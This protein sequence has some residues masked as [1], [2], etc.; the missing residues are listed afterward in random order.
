M[1]Q[2]YQCVNCG[3]PVAFGAKFCSNC[4]LQLNWA[5]QQQSPPPQNQRPQ[6]PTK[7]IENKPTTGRVRIAAGILMIIVGIFSL[8]TP[9]MIA[10]AL[11]L[12]ATEI[13]GSAWIVC[14][15][16]F[17][18]GWIGGGGICAFIKK[19]WWWALS[20]AICSVLVGVIYTI[21]SLITFP[22]PFYSFGKSN[23]AIAGTVIGAAIIGCVLTLM[24]ILAF[25]FL[26]KSKG[27]FR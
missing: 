15:A 5:I 20:G 7:V 6:Q 16:L 26:R 25:I 9:G 19:A 4:G 1:Q 22:L 3:A 27:Q 11:D 13:V 23:A 14:L 18:L 8:S 21:T 10:Q 2:Q 17:L 12:T 24:G